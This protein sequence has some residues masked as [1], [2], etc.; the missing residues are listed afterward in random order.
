MIKKIRIPKSKH[1]LGYTKNEI[2]LI[3]K[4]LDIKRDLFNKVAGVNTVAVDEKTGETLMYRYDVQRFIEHISRG[5][6]LIWD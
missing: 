3:L 1:D 2:D 6:P 5:R 4:R